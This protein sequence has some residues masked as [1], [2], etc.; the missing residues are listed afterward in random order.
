MVQQ[1]NRELFSHWDLSTNNGISFPKIE[2]LLNSST[3]SLK[4]NTFFT[5]LNTFH[6]AFNFQLRNWPVVLRK[7]SVA[8]YRDVDGKYNLHWVILSGNKSM[9]LIPYCFSAVVTRSSGF[10]SDCGF[11]N[12]KKF[13]VKSKPWKGELVIHLFPP[14]STLND[15]KYGKITEIVKRHIGKRIFYK[16]SGSK[17][18]SLWFRNETRKTTEQ[19][20]LA[21]QNTFQV[22]ILVGKL[23]GKN[24]DNDVKNMEGQ[25]VLWH[26]NVLTDLQYDSTKVHRVARIFYL[27]LGSKHQ[28]LTCISRYLCLMTRADFNLNL[29]WM[30]HIIPF[31]L[32]DRHQL[33]HAVDKHLDLC[34]NYLTDF[35]HKSPLNQLMLDFTASEERLAHV[36]VHILQLILRNYTFSSENP[37]GLLCSNGKLVSYFD[38]DFEALE[39]EPTYQ[40]KLSFVVEQNELL[41]L[42]PVMVSNEANTL[43]FITCGQRG[44]QKYAFDALVSTYGGYVWS[45]ILAV[46]ALGS[47]VIPFSRKSNFE[48]IVKVLVEQGSPFPDNLIKSN[49]RVRLPVAAFLLMGIVLSNGY[50][51]TNVYRMITPRVTLQYETLQHLIEDKFEIYTRTSVDTDFRM[52]N[53]SLEPLEILETFGDPDGRHYK[54]GASI[55]SEV[56][57]YYSKDKEGM[58]ILSGSRRLLIHRLMNHSRLHPHNVGKELILANFNI[59]KDTDYWPGPEL[60]E[61][62]GGLRLRKQYF[63]KESLILHNELR[64]CDKTAL[65]LPQNVCFQFAKNLTKEKGARSVYIG[66]E[67]FVEFYNGFL[68]S[69]SVPL[70]VFAR[71]RRLG[72][73]GI[74]TRWGK[75]LRQLSL[76]DVEN[77]N[78]DA[79]QAAKLNGNVLVVFLVLVCGLVVS[80][81]G[82]LLEILFMRFR[83]RVCHGY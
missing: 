30:K 55:M 12:I 75:L 23:T 11:I 35:K 65:I 1:I 58:A 80:L 15:Q 57:R 64:K 24:M 78:E 27:E 47:F 43:R 69:N 82:F 72:Q 62:D 19:K 60:N 37:Q 67:P 44:V 49:L 77:R 54:F 26:Q 33:F 13:A 20:S 71:V 73:S 48:P 42:L 28:N 8:I 3:F 32:S 40:P 81:M 51:N 21:S 14:T 29:V 52:Y 39:R 16:Y 17:C 10:W 46:M 7:W 83:N 6:D 36:Y 41:H 66:K 61:Q 25:L 34:W 2:T 45:L 31:Y 18:Y 9:S 53:F 50:K 38:F 76:T 70:S 63:E 59:T 74:E 22:H 5:V 79:P 68:F 4:L 56:S